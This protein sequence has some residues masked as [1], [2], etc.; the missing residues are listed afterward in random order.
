M[1][2]HLGDLRIH[3][4]FTRFIKRNPPEVEPPNIRK[5][6]SKDSE[7]SWEVLYFIESSP[8]QILYV[9][10]DMQ[11]EIWL[12]QI[13]L[14]LPCCQR[15]CDMSA[16]PILGDHMTMHFCFFLRAGLF[17]AALQTRNADITNVEATSHVEF[18]TFYCNSIKTRAVVTTSLRQTVS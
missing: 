17:I 16:D 7:T 13:R 12:Y 18:G 3:V 14:R 5:S 15:C 11:P 4:L 6:L 1:Q 10:S 8:S 2:E 9:C